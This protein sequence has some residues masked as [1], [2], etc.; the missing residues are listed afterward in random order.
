MSDSIR[1]LVVVLDDDHRQDSETVRALIDAIRL[2]KGVED[3]CPGD[4]VDFNT[5]AAR[6]IAKAELRVEILKA[7][8]PSWRQKEKT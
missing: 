1:T 8:Q 3:V 4:P 2:L 6:D 7:L 5:Y